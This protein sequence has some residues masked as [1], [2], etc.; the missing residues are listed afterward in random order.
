MLAEPPDTIYSCSWH[1]TVTVRLT[2]EQPDCVI[3]VSETVIV[4][5]FIASVT[6]NVFETGRKRSVVP[7]QCFPSY[8]LASSPPC[9]QLAVNL[10]T[11]ILGYTPVFIL[12]FKKS[13]P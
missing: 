11:H 9:Q 4:S 6:V 12:C 8:H 5:T 7:L 3:P 1:S 2:S 10:V 13:D